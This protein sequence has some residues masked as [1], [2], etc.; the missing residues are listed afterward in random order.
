MSMLP[1]W[2]NFCA[3]PWPHHVW[4]CGRCQYAWTSHVKK[5]SLPRCLISLART[6]RLQQSNQLLVLA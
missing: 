3:R 6:C 2:K 4:L 1:P 5:T